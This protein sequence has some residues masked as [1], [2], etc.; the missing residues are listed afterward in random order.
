MKF[1]GRVLRFFVL[2]S[3]RFVVSDELERT[4]PTLFSKAASLT[5]MPMSF[6]INDTHSLIYILCGDLDGQS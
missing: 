3:E 2:K 6:E 5:R 4:E 1:E